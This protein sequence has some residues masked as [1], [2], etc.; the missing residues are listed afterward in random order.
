MQLGHTSWDATGRD[1][2]Q[3]TMS[4]APLAF[5]SLM[6]PLEKNSP[7]KLHQRTHVLPTAISSLNCR[8]LP[9]CSITVAS[10][11]PTST[12][13]ATVTTSWWLEAWVFPFRFTTYIAM[14]FA[15][16]EQ[17]AP[18]RL[19]SSNLFGSVRT[20]WSNGP[21]DTKLQM[22]QD[23]EVRPKRTRSERL[24]LAKKQDDSLAPW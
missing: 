17:L 23:L 4:L 5:N 7:E 3:K 15:G 22:Q 2:E 13:M 10:L 18:E 14:D 8:T 6:V 9:H 11:S 1:K 12:R 20:H 16:P 19:R 24:S 21:R